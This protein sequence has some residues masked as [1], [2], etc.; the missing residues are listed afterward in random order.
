MVMKRVLLFCPGSQANWLF[1]P[2]AFNLFSLFFIFHLYWKML[3]KVTFSNTKC[4][5][6]LGA[7]LGGGW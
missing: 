1:L 3:L 6:C 2:T 5:M 4:L 7:P